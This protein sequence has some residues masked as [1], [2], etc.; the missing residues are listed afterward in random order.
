MRRTAEEEAQSGQPV[1]VRFIHGKRINVY[2]YT[3]QRQYP[4]DKMISLLRNYVNHLTGV[5][6]YPEGVRKSTVES[7]YMPAEMVSCD[8]WADFE[9]VYQIHSPNLFMC[10]AVRDVSLCPSLEVKNLIILPGLDAILQL[11]QSPPR[12]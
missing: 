8:E 9:N 12:L 2:L 7:Y 6:Q 4:L 5:D 1:Q 10:N 11:F 3:F